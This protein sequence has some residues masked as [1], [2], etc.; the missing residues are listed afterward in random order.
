M[1]WIKSVLAWLLQHGEFV[2][3]V[4][5]IVCF[6]GLLHF[7]DR[8][9]PEATFKHYFII[10]ALVLGYSFWERVAYSVHI[11]KKQQTKAQNA[12]ILTFT[13]TAP[14]GEES[15]KLKTTISLSNNVPE[16]GNDILKASRALIDA[17]HEARCEKK[18]IKKE[19][20]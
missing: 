6:L 3:Q 10:F 1:E 7:I 13:M 4:F 17:S 18:I 12:S 15:V 19:R 2:A 16:W 20:E 8:N 9:F 14:E 11:W 5:S